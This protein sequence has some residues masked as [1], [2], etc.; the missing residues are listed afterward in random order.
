[1][2]GMGIFSTTEYSRNES[3]ELEIV[4]IRRGGLRGRCCGLRPLILRGFCRSA[5]E[6][7]V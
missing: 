1:M 6:G 7:V 4:T 5:M 3:A 2:E